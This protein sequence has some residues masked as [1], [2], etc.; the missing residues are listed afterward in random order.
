M[1][2]PDQPNSTALPEHLR[3]PPDEAFWRHRLGFKGYRWLEPKLA[4]DGW[5]VEQVKELYKGAIARELVSRLT[6]D[7]AYTGTVR[8]HLVLAAKL[9]EG[10]KTSALIDVA[11]A[12]VGEHE[13]KRCEQGPGRW[14]RHPLALMA[15]VVDPAALLSMVVC[16]R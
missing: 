6:A 13:A 11:C 1:S 4:D 8:Q 3:Q 9:V 5:V 15:Y 16:D 10:L 7:P 12:L 14:A 2:S